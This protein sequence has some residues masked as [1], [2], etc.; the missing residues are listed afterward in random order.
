MLPQKT[1]KPFFK[2]PLNLGLMV[3]VYIVQNRN[4]SKS[5]FQFWCTNG[6]MSSNP[7]SGTAYYCRDASRSYITI[8]TKQRSFIFEEKCAHFCFGNFSFVATFG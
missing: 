1:R 7:T 4:Y 8:K 5:L 6:S 3:Y 2:T